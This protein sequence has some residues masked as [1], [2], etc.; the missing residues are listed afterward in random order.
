MALHIQ[1]AVSLHLL[2][3]V[4]VLWKEI[5]DNDGGAGDVIVG[6]YCV[7]NEKASNDSWQDNVDVKKGLVLIDKYGGG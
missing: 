4:L 2:C 3:F 1:H 6:R 7:A 5:G